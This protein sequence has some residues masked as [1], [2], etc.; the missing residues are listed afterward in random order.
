MSRI[1]RLDQKAFVSSW[2]SKSFYQTDEDKK[3]RYG[4]Q[5]LIVS[6]SLII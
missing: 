2:Q 5:E 6:N 1:V 3:W 4:I